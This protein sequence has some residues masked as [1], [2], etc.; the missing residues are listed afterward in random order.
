MSDSSI[1]AGSGASDLAVG[2]VLSR[3]WIVFTNNFVIFFITALVISLPGLLIESANAPGAAANPSSVLWKIGV[4]FPLALILNTIGEAVIVFGA[5]Q[6]LRG[7][8][9]RLGEALQKGLARFF[10]ILGLA[11]VSSLGI[12]IGILL[13]V[14][15]GV[16]LAIMWSVA[17]PVCVLE[18]LGP[19]SSLGRSSALTKGYRWKIFGMVLLLVIANFLGSFVVGLVLAPVS[20]MTVAIGGLV[21][22][23]LWTAYYNSVLVMI[24]HDL[25]VSK[26]GVDVEQIAAVFD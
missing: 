4:G 12:A 17:L 23:A 19:I 24:Y 22:T 21:W 20:F 9:V 14:V 16:I 26:E 8:P 15:P 1:Y 7:Q 2:R 5:F 3:A 6:D 25:R 10:P 11:V 18:Q 13:V